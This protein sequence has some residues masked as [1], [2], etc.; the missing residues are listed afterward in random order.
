[1]VVFSMS[2]L[3]ELLCG[4][5]LDYFPAVIDLTTLSKEGEGFQECLLNEFCLM[6]QLRAPLL[7]QVYN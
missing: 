2:L 6:D 5:F 3:T 4:V 7:G 1:M